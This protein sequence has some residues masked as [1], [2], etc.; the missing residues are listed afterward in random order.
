MEIIKKYAD[1][2]STNEG[3][4]GIGR[5]K[6]VMF[7]SAGKKHKV[8]VNFKDK[9]TFKLKI[10]NDTDIVD[11]QGKLTPDGANILFTYLNGQNS[12]TGIYGK[13]DDTF[14]ASKFLTYEVK[15]DNE[16]KQVITFNVADRATVPSLPKDTKYISAEDLKSGN[17]GK[18]AQAILAKVDAEAKVTIPEPKKEVA[19]EKPQAIV[20]TVD[21][22][23]LPISKAAVANKVDDNVKATQI[24]I[25]DKFK[26]TKLK[27]NATFKKFVGF[28]GDG[29][30]GITT[31][32]VIAMMKNGF[33]LPDK[34]GSTITNDL[35]TK[36]ETEKV[37]ESYFTLDYT[38]YE[39]FDFDAAVATKQIVP[40]KK[41]DTTK[42][43]DKKP[44]PVTKP[45]D[46]KSLISSA[47]AASAKMQQWFATD[48]NLAP[49][50]S[51]NLATGGDDE[52]GAKKAF[53]SYWNTQIQPKYM[54]PI[55]KGK[56]S[57][58]DSA[59]KAAVEAAESAVISAY[60]SIQK[61][62]TGSSLDDTVKWNIIDLDG[63][64]TS[65]SV[66]TD[67]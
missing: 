54:S 9:D 45:G 60:A 25:A 28:G 58:T 63:N 55:A 26:D 27:D 31:Q 64:A 49:Y 36:L 40:V 15:R 18:E 20:S 62:M 56:V 51:D 8:V 30:Y 35:I 7:D 38:M 24:L 22:T 23:K 6:E 12:F 43:D 17:L 4:F 21:K 53:V 34:D 61:T 41:T 10:I 66:D 3:L 50:K 32:N 29:R 5:S 44:A 47:N 57:I 16:R 14:Y 48:A 2:K 33:G 46:A 65:Y 37:T 67:F 39:A 19:P 11:P 1:W 13:L 59:A 42:K 52:E